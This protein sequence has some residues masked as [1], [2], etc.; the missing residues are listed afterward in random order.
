MTNHKSQ[1]TVGPCPPPDQ[2]V[3]LIHNDL[4]ADQLAVVADHVGGCDGCQHRLDLLAGGGATLPNVVRNIRAADP[5]P[6][7]AFWQALANAEQAL[8]AAYPDAPPPD[9]RLDFLRPAETPGSLGK[10]GRFDIR[11]VIGRGGMGVVL[12]AT[13]PSLARDVAI[14]ILDPQ[15]SSND[16]AR[17]RFCR[18]ARAAAAVPN[19]NLVAVYQVD[20]DADSGLPFLVMQLVDGESLEQRLRRVG[21][22]AP[23]EVV[24]VGVQAAAGLAAAHA[25]GLIHRDI[26]PGN[27][28]IERGTEKVRLTDFGLARAT[29]DLKLTKTGFVAGTPLYMAPEQARGDEIDHRADLFSLGSVLYEALAGKPPFDGKTPLAVLRRVAD[30][31]HPR[32]RRLNRDV[33]EWLE[34]VID[35]LLA[36]DPG[37]RFQTAAEVAEVLAAHAPVGNRSPVQ[38][39]ACGPRSHLGPRARRKVCVR[40]LGSLAA[41]FLTGTLLGGAGVMLFRP[42][43]VEPMAQVVEKRV[44]VPG[45][46]AAAAKPDPGPAPRAVLPGKSGAVWAVAVSRDGGTLAMGVENGRVGIWD[47]AAQRLRFDLHPPDNDQAPAHRGVIWAAGFTEAGD[48]LVTAG[49]DGLVNVWQVSDGRQLRSL[50]ASPSLRSAAVSLSGKLVAVGDREGVVRVFDLTTDQPL[51]KFQTDTTVTA[52]AFDGYEVA[53]AAGGADGKVTLWDLPNNRRR[54]TLAGHTGPVYGLAF[55]SMD[56][57]RLASAGWDGTAVVWDLKTTDKLKVLE[58]HDDGVWGVE[59]TPCGQRLATTGQD[60]RVAVWDTDTGAEV[61]SFRQHRGAVHAV[62]FSGTGTALASGGRDGTVRVWTIDCK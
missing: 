41:T 5:P 38:V 25:Q 4:S 56:S 40:T 27:I 59:F 39:A 18:E 54:S 37:E 12:R 47:V 16:L 11:R 52:L 30:E 62:R 1:I 31:A 20:E 13:D 15:L 6:D 3:G 50:A 22:L 60:G 42:A 35:Q 36:K 57:E 10:L 21:R 9:V 23:D 29:E 46:A 53:V 45:P 17:Q 14:K 2:L 49:D 44:E 58:P 28:L 8:T 48:K 19:D 24:R 43:G 7:S 33:P 55:S 26:K 51:L 32:L 61:L 34:D